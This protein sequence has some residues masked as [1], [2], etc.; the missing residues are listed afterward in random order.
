MGMHHTDVG[1]AYTVNACPL[2]AETTF[3]FR[4]SK[5]QASANWAMQHTME[6]NSVAQGLCSRTMV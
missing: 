6:Y 5:N 3:F 1:H 4:G 2:S